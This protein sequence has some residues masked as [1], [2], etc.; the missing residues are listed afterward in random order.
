MQMVAKE[1]VGKGYIWKNFSKTVNLTKKWPPKNWAQ[2]KARML[3][4]RIKN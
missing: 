4:T 1:T 3:D 2:V